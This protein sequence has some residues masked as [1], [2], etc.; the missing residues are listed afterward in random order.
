M[1]LSRSDRIL[2]DEL[3]RDSTR[4]QAELAELAGMS[5]S[6]CWR[7]IREFEDKGLIT[8]QVALLDHKQA[9]FEI[10]V[11]L[12]VSM[13]EHT[14]EN[15]QS[16]EAHV[17]RLDVVMECFTVAGD[18][19]YVLQIVVP[20]MDSYTEFLNLEILRHPAVRSASSTFVLR[21]IK[22]ST[23]LPMNRD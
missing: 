6:S 20:D 21:R 16:F 7:R 2:L 15:R 17:N 1:K 12:A 18:R 3:Q 19:D 9:G 14:D 11:L 4:N 22:Y 10:Q 13:V 8:R 5:R 23:R